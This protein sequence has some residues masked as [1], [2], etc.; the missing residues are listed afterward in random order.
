MKNIFFFLLFALLTVGAHSQSLLQL[1]KCIGFD[2]RRFAPEPR[3]S[4]FNIS[5][6][7]EAY[8]TTTDTS[9]FFNLF[10]DKLAG[11]SKLREQIIAGVPENE[12]RDIEG[13]AA[14]VTVIGKIE[15][16]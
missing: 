4:N 7:I 3:Q 1:E 12:I 8:K 2:L 14:V 11:N 6:L 15:H 5:W 9:A 13:L 16:V 10:F